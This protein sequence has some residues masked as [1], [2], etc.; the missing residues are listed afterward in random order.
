[1]KLIIF[2]IIMIVLMIVLNSILTGIIKIVFDFKD[3]V[4]YYI[5]IQKKRIINKIKN[6]ISKYGHKEIKKEMELN[7]NSKKDEIYIDADNSKYETKDLITEYETY[8]YNILLELE[9]EME[10][11]IQSQVNLA[12]II[13]KISNTKYQTELFRNIDFG[14]F[15]K[16]CKK[17]LLLI[18]IND[19]THNKPEKIKR[20]KKVKEILKKANIRLITF[21]STMPNKKEYVK[22]RIKQELILINNNN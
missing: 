1:M 3:K 19:K 10:I 12:T 5:Y 14:I 11:R 9:N 22:N 15:T 7:V 6:K 8:F 4:D 17:I 18:E 13:N 20:D 16:D 21:Y 2:T